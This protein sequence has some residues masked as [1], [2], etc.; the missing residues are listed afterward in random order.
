MD[1][2]E[3]RQHIWHRSFLAQHRYKMIFTTIPSIIAP[4][5]T[6]SGFSFQ[7]IEEVVMIGL[8]Y[9]QQFNKMEEQKMGCHVICILLIFKTCLY[10]IVYKV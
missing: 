4:T 3:L 10:G 2:Y 9:V 6:I 7:K 8:N 1:F 5:E